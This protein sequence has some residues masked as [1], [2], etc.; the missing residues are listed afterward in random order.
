MPGEEHPIALGADGVELGPDV[1]DA[2]APVV[3]QLLPGGL[4]GGLAGLDLGEVAGV[5]FLEV[6]FA[7][8][9]GLGQVLLVLGL[10]GREVGLVLLGGLGQG[11]GIAHPRPP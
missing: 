4:V 6:A 2:V 9:L 10:G 8:G 5:E 1:A 7:V 3:D 11:L